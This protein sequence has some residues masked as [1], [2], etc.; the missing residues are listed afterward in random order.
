V[1]AALELTDEAGRPLDTALADM[2]FRCE[3]RVDASG[4]D[5]WVELHIE[6][7]TRLEDAGVP[8]GIVTDIA[9]ITHSR[10]RIRGELDHA[11]ATPMEHRI[12]ALPAAAELV[13]DIEA[14]ARD[15]VKETSESAVGTIGR[16]EVEPNA[17][18]VVPGVVEL[19]LD[20]RDVNRAG[21]RG[22]V[23]G[24]RPEPRAPGIRTRRRYRFR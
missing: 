2:G 4:W 5:G 6:Q 24:G 23:G 16:V 9:G 22:G 3:G 1:E 18:N 20:V 14:A 8:V 10:V 7:A 17:T 21:H 15:A 11:G 13:L 12:D 19:E